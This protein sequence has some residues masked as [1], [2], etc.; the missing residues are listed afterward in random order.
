VKK[1]DESNI[2]LF[3][4]DL[5][6]IPYEVKMTHKEKH[7]DEI[8]LYELILI[9]KKRMKYIASVFVFGV[10]TAAVI[11]FLMPNIYQAKATLWVDYS[12]IQAIVRNLKII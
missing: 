2:L 7:S 8:D 11:S 4:K 5:E 10:V 1:R 12:L 9:L 3:F 6:I